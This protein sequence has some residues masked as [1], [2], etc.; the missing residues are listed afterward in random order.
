LL[1][2]VVPL[3]PLLLLQLALPLQ[4][5]LP[6]QPLKE[7]GWLSEVLV[8]EFW[9]RAGAEIAPAIAAASSTL[10]LVFM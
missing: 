1:W 2:L 6:L 3:Q 7:V 4:L 10:V 5:V 9:A 8:L